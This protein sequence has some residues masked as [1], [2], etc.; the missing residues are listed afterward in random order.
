[1]YVCMYVCMYVYVYVCKYACMYVCIYIYMY[2]VYIV[3]CQPL[4]EC[5]TYV[6]YTRVDN[7]LTNY[8]TCLQY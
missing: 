2:V 4:Y 3:T 8:N 1:M 6:V 7:Q 5:N